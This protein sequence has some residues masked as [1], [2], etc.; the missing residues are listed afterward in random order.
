MQLLKLSELA[1]I[2]QKHVTQGH[3]NK[4]TNK[5]FIVLVEASQQEKALTAAHQISLKHERDR[6]HS[7]ITSNHNN[8]NTSLNFNS[9]VY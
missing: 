5:S 6:I 4:H 3:K 2:L 9:E 1:A 8:I 7:G